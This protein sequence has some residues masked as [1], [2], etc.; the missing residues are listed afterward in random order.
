MKKILI[1]DSCVRREESRTKQMLDKAVETLKSRHEDWVF[2]T[3]TLMDMDLK[4]WNTESLKVRDRLLLNGQHDAPQFR[5]GNQ[6]RE[7]DGIVIAAPFWDLSVPAMLKVYIEN[8]SADGI[9]FSTSEEGLTGICKFQWMLFLTTRGGIWEGSD[10]EM[11]SPYM[12]ALSRFFGNGK[13]YCVAA[14]GTD[15]V[16]LDLEEIMEKTLK[17]VEGVCASLGIEDRQKM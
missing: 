1:I 2:E 6:F 9:T 13:Y 4:Y 11:G 17:E 14:D 12:E 10:M 8:I 15:I 3:L 5:L 7:A 16:G